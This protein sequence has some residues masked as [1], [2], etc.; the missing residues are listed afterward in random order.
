MTARDA[1][2]LWD[3]GQE[4]FLKLWQKGQPVVLRR[5]YIDALED[6]T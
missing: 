1:Y 5:M 6:C 3:S 2:L 4:D